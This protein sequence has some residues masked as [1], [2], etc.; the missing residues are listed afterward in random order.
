MA[1]N[2]NLLV[3]NVERLKESVNKWNM[4]EDEFIVYTGSTA[5]TL[6]GIMVDSFN[7]PFT[8]V[9]LIGL[10]DKDLNSDNYDMFCTYINLSQNEFIICNDV[11]ITTPRRAI[12]DLVMIN[13]VN[14]IY[15]LE[16]CIEGTEWEEI[17]KEVKKELRV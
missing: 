8:I 14:D 7:P 2:I 13:N 9:N 17:Y 3:K 6:Y 5:L 1:I 4:S 11:K 12:K 15:E 10:L 16:D